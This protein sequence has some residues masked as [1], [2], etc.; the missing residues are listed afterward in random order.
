MNDVFLSGII[1]TTPKI[2]SSHNETPHAIMDLTVTHRS[3]K[4]VEKHEQ[5]PLSAW[6]GIATKMVELIKPGSHVS[7]K[8]Y[9]SQK[10]TNDGVFL[11]ITVE[12]FNVAAR[13]IGIRPLRG[14]NSAIK[15]PQTK[16]NLL[17]PQKD[18]EDVCHEAEECTQQQNS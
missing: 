14:I 5:Y 16:S 17:Q 2:V 6:R 10:Q 7:I 8:G 13:S 18:A 15:E 9:L 3:A 1:K 4:G 11:E 12:E